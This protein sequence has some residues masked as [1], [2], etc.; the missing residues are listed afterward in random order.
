MK[1][2]PG[3][4]EASSDTV[5]DGLRPRI[6]LSTKLRIGCSNQ[7]PRIGKPSFINSLMVGITIVVTFVLEILISGLEVLLIS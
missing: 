1:P 6:E 2:I 5:T 4:N 3:P 7:M